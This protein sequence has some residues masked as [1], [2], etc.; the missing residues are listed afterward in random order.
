MLGIQGRWAPNTV[1]ENNRIEDA[2]F[3]IYLEQ[4]ADSIVRGNA[5]IGMDL[6]ISRR[7]DGLKIWYSP[8]TLV[9]GNVMRDTRDAHAVVFALQLLCAAT[10][11]PTGR[12]GLH[13]MQ[14]DHHLIEDN[15]FRDNSVGVYIMYGTGFT[16]GATCLR[17]IAGRAATAS[18]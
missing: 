14:S 10:T 5:I 1:L 13:M 18:G 17:T 15:V 3:G 12:Y 11:W 2:L 9:E 8:R 7:G 6:P 16:C 4:A